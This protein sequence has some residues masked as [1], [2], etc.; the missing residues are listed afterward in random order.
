V[1]IGNWHACLAYPTVLQCRCRGAGTCTII[2]LD[3]ICVEQGIAVVPS[4]HTLTGRALN[5]PDLLHGQAKRAWQDA[6]LPHST[7]SHL[8]SDRSV[9]TVNMALRDL[10][11]WVLP[12]FWCEWLAQLH[13]LPRL[14]TRIGRFLSTM[15][16]R[17]LMDCCTCRR[18]ALEDALTRRY[19]PSKL[20][21]ATRMTAVF[22]P[23]EQV[24]PCVVNFNADGTLW[25]CVNSDCLLTSLSQ[26]KASPEKSQQ[27]MQEIW[28]VLPDIPDSVFSKSVVQVV[29]VCQV[30]CH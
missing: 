27:A 23:P 24:H 12:N 21:D 4:C 11:C 16:S 30:R 5:V 1:H 6:M 17:S 29:H 7:A 10:P 3:A 25:A 15:S 18:C 8:P 19:K 22:A 14:R 28:D 13:Q 2:E 20:E 26:Q 9:R